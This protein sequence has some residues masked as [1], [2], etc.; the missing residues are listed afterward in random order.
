[1][2]ATVGVVGLGRLGA[3]LAAAMAAKGVRVIGVDADARKVE[4]INRGQAP[5]HEPGLPELLAQTQGRLTAL[6]QIEPAVGQAD[7][8][9]IVVATPSE[10]GGG[11]SLHFVE[12]VCR[13]IGS[14]LASRND[15]HVVCLTSTVMPGTTG[16]RVRALLEEASGKRCGQDFGLCYSPEFVAL[17]SVIHDF[18]NPDL[19]L[20][21]ESDPRAG[22]A[23]EALY[24]KICDNRPAVA[25]MNFVNA[26]VTKL[27]VNTYVTAKI[28]FANLLARI[29]ERLPGAD[30]DVITSALGLDTRIGR[31][32]LKG[33]VSYGGPCF[34]RD[35]LALAEL[36]RRLDV[37]PDLAQSVDRFN[38]F[39]IHW[40]ADYILHHAPGTV[41][42]LGLTYKPD[43]NVVEEAFGSLLAKELAERGATVLAYDPS[44]QENPACRL[45]KRIRPAAS[46]QECIA[47]SDLVVV[48]TPWPEFCSISP[49]Q[50]ARPGAPRTVIDCWRV[51]RRL[52]HQPGVA[53][54]GLGIGGGLV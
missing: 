16:G 26:E 13:A 9:F 29:S 32:Y 52:Q 46:A 10:P 54:F 11:F 44:L 47:G 19:L 42:I 6:P 8:T 22:D 2:T 40:L 7:L 3:P 14:A 37:P 30:V 27:A 49:Q 48:A 39:Q 1:M 31:K 25:R 24:Q 50:W 33:A 43:T 12:P 53:Y 36:A 5:V 4:A 18:L 45:D 15:Y 35:N 21:G 38:R 34:P 28:S 51:L 23:L 41:G 17:G 20:I